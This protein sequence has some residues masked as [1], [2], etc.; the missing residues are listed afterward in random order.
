LP[1]FLQAR[2]YEKCSVMHGWGSVQPVEAL[3]QPV[4]IETGALAEFV[5]RARERRNFVAGE[6][7]LFVEVAEPRARRPGCERRF[8]RCWRN[9][10]SPSTA[11]PHRPAE[12]GVVRAA[13]ERGGGAGPE[14]AIERGV[15]Q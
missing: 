15:A 8:K 10:G 2:G 4:R 9:W 14:P 6:S 3:W 7:G 1:D 5:A 12:A 11:L 13:D